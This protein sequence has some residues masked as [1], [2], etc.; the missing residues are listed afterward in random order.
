[1]KHIKGGVVEQ[2]KLDKILAY[3]KAWVYDHNEALNV[4]EIYYFVDVL[5]SVLQKQ[6]LREREF[7]GLEDCIC[8][9]CGG[10]VI[11]GKCMSNC[12]KKGV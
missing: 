8:P 12:T 6:P 3:Q 1:M 11:L 5:R 10:R 4:N 9:E 7:L 2:A